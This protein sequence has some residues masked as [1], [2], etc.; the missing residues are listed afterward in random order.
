M[1]RTKFK[2]PFVVT[3]VEG[4]PIIR[5][6]FPGT[7]VTH[8]G[9]HPGPG[10]LKGYPCDVYI[11]DG[12]YEEKGRV[13]NSFTWRRVIQSSSGGVTLGKTIS[14]QGSFHACKNQYNLKSIKIK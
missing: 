14:G 4:V 8:T 3:D 6:P 1:K 11:V 5:E 10:I 7:I 13:K 9:W 2:E 12:K